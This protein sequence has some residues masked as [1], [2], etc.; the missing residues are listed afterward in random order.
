[1]LS[2]VKFRLLALSQIKTENSSS[3]CSDDE[4][5]GNITNLWI[6]SLAIRMQKLHQKKPVSQP[7]AR[8]DN[9]LLN[10]FEG[11]DLMKNVFRVFCFFKV[12]VFSM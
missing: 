12:Q 5:L 4:L 1:M 7:G 3:H 10:G 8:Q 6:E 11:D 2:S 9:P